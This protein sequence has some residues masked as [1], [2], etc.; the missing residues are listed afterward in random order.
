MTRVFLLFKNPMFRSGIESLLDC[1]PGMEIVGRAD[2]P[3]QAIKLILEQRPDVIVVDNGDSE[4]KLSTVIN[5]LMK[6]GLRIKVIGMNLQDNSVTIYHGE[7]R[8][9]KEVEDLIEAI[10]DKSLPIG[11]DMEDWA[12]L[13]QS[14]SRIY[15]FLAAVYNRL[16]DEQF[17]RNLQSAEMGEFFSTLKQMED[18]PKEMREGIQLIE[19]YVQSRREYSVEE[20]LTELAVERTRLLRGIKPGYGPP[21]PYESVYLGSDQSPIIQTIMTVQ[22]A[23]TE[24]GVGLPEEVKD[25]PDFIGFELDF[26]RHLTEQEAQSW[27]THSIDEA[28]MRQK[29][30]Q[31]FLNDHISKWMIRFCE[32]MFQD[33]RI[34]FFR[35][36][37]RMTK[38]FIQD[39]ILKV[40]MFQS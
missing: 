5:S 39:E 34:D 38:G 32:I 14:R 26:M 25:Q 30:E 13:A 19:R 31:A 2:E 40:A 4:G 9:V 24:A 36:I 16:P 10:E 23:Y 6:L 37:A 11:I 12:T 21:P 8:I 18:L 1:K 20:L 17:A 33:T 22:R 29:E 27:K 28:G 15:G 3:E 7:K 35:G